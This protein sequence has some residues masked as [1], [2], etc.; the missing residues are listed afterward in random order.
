MDIVEDIVVGL[1]E[2]QT[3]TIAAAWPYPDYHRNGPQASYCPV[4]RNDSS[5]AALERK[6]LIKSLAEGG[7]RLTQLGLA[8]RAALT[9]PLPLDGV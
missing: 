6:R 4:W 9:P 3:E 1:T 8:V 2:A 5:R 7:P